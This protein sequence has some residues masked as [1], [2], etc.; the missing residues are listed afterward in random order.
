M[1]RS[2]FNTPYWC[3][4]NSYAPITVND[5]VRKAASEIAYLFQS[6]DSTQKTDSW[7]QGYHHYAVGK[8]REITKA[9]FWTTVSIGIPLVLCR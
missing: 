6:V 1:L 4:L 9:V 8:T 7:N 3:Y 2:N 5:L